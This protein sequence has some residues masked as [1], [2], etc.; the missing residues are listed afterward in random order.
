MTHICTLF[1][2]LAYHSSLLTSLK[3][4]DSWW[5]GI[6]KG[7]HFILWLY[8][9]GSQ[10]KVDP[11]VIPFTRF[12]NPWLGTLKRVCDSSVFVVNFKDNDG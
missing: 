7:W 11:T 8:R 2:H 10:G 6:R 4:R 5:F 9:R 3:F 1:Y 12:K